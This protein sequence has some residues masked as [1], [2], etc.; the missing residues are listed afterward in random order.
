MRKGHAGSGA[1]RGP[2]GAAFALL[3]TSTS[4]GAWLPPLPPGDPLAADIADAPLDAESATVIAWL[5]G[6]GGFGLGRMQIDFSLELNE[7][8]PDAPTLPLAP[9]PGYYMPDCDTGVDVPLPPGGAI[10]GESGYHCDASSADCH[11]L[12]WQPAA[13]ALHESYQAD[14]SGGVLRAT[15]LVRWQLDASYGPF[16]RGLQCTSADAA[17]L[18][19]AP[20]LFDADEVASGEIRH[21]IRFILPNPRM[22][23][24]TFVLPATH[25]GAPSG[26]AQAPPYGARFRLRAD[27]PLETLPNEAART[28]ARALQRYG[29]VLADGGNVALTARSDRYTGTKWAGLLGP[30][31]LRLLKVTDFAMIEAGTRYPLTYDCGREHPTPAATPNEVPALPKFFVGVAGLLL[32]LAGARRLRRRGA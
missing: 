29:M 25:A 14:V 8:A 10:E 17:G 31:D 21:A 13:N 15:C 23:A 9:R 18:P 6:A 28:V 27:F 2:A 11:L 32:A 26:P 5:D 7:A 1:G 24:G 19:I 30:H 12:V 4:V 22:R 3:V 16:R 20:L